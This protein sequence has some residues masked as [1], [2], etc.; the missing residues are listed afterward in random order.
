MNTPAVEIPDSLV[1]AAIERADRHRARDVHAVPVWEI[2]EHLHIVRRSAGA[3]HVRVR[4]DVLEAGGRI[5]HVRLHGSQA[6]EITA[7]GR[8]YLQRHRRAGNVPEL[9]ESPQHTA[10]REARAVAE[11]RIGGLGVALRETLIEALDLI[12]ADPPTRSDVWFEL[13]GTLR[14]ASWRL[15]CAVYCLREWVEPDDAHADIDDRLTP[16]EKKLD[17]AEQARLRSRRQGRRGITHW[18]TAAGE[19]D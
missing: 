5:Q 14:R 7:A 13:A 9:P 16:A 19:R 2:F 18:S 1:L 4:L 11:S 12:E 6:W 17:R 8:R 3:R 15:G 10:W